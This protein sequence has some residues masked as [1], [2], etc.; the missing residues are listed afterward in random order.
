MNEIMLTTEGETDVISHWV[1]KLSQKAEKQTKNK[2]TVYNDTQENQNIY[3]GQHSHLLLMLGRGVGCLL[4][5][6]LGQGLSPFHLKEEK[7]RKIWML[8]TM[9]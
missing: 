4:H 3:L 5:I 2:E 1:P 6:H 7:R 8:R 9:G